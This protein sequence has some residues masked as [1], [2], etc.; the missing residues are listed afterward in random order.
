ML[1]YHRTKAAEAILREGFRHGEGS[2]MAEGSFRGIWVS[3]A[4]P[5]GEQE[6]ASGEA[7]L[8]LAVPEALFS[9]YEWVEEGKTYREALIPAA[10]LNRHLESARLLSEAEA[11]ELAARA[12]AGGGGWGARPRPEP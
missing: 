10:E 5:L 4:W 8:E 3:A 2:F 7:V 11:D 12:G 1:V 9:E 6:G